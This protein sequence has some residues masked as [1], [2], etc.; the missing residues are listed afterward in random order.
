MAREGLERRLGREGGPITL[1]DYSGKNVTS[2]FEVNVGL[3]AGNATLKD[4][5]GGEGGTLSYTSWFS[6]VGVLSRMAKKKLILE[7][8]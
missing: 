8:M 5:L 3:L 1:L 7:V 4:I 6:N 2:D